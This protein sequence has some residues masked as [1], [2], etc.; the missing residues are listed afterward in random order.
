VLPSRHPRLPS[1]E[2]RGVSAF[3]W[4]RFWR[5][6]LVLTRGDPAIERNSESVQCR[7]PPRCP[8][9]SSLPGRV[10]GSG[11]QIQTLQRGLLVGELSAGPGRPAVSRVDALSI[12]LVLQMTRLISGS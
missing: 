4:I 10:Q 5:I 3:R 7:L 8:S 2:P 9:C 12:A 6:G 11:R 1:G